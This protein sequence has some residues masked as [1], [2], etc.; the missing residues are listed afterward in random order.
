MK[1]IFRLMK[2]LLINHSGPS[3][4][5]SWKDLATISRFPVLRPAIEILPSVVMKRP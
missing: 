4:V 1:Y 5:T 2:H 3:L